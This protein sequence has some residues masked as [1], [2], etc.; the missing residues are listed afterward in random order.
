MLVEKRNSVA[1]GCALSSDRRDMLDNPRQIL[2]ER[3]V[4]YLRGLR[5]HGLLIVDG[6][7][8]CESDCVPADGGWTT[9]FTGGLETPPTVTTT[10]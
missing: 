7:S 6:L 9:T 3:D 4:V 10:G 5:K 2:Q 1:R 8:Y